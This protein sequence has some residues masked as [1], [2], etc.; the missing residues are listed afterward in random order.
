MASFK[1]LKWNVAQQ[2]EMKKRL[3][4]VITWEREC[5]K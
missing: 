4:K 3:Q 5:D 2:K 1:Y